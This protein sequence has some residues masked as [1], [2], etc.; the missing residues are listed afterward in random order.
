LIR[1]SGNLKI[2]NCFFGDENEAIFI[3]TLLANVVSPGKLELSDVT[4]KHCDFECGSIAIDGG[5]LILNEVIFSYLDVI[6]NSVINVKD[7]NVKII[8]SLF[9]DISL[10]DGNGSVI[11]ANVKNSKRVDIIGIF[12]FFLFFYFI[13][14]C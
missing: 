5:E 13:F 6:E 9:N 10:Q 1:C 7:G 3:G 8:R 2:T 12:Y 14:F 11:N 4:I